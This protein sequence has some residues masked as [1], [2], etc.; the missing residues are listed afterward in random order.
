MTEFLLILNSRWESRGPSL[1]GW[2]AGGSTPAG[3]SQSKTRELGG[4]LMLTGA[5][6]PKVIVSSLTTVWEKMKIRFFFMGILILT[7]ILS[8]YYPAG[9][10]KCT[11]KSINSER[12]LN[13]ITDMEWLLTTWCYWLTHVT[14]FTG[15]FH[16]FIQHGLLCFRLCM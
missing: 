3:C 15:L 12:Y 10:T 8:C 13:G 6:C 5:V 14:V 1:A 2:L 7:I 9:E 4:V 16:R 11:L